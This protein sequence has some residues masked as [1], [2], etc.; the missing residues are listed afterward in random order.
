MILLGN[1]IAL[2]A[3]IF[4]VIAGLLKDRKRIIY[5]QSIQIFLFILS[6]AVLGGITGVITNLISLIRN[7]LCYKD[8]FN[9]KVKIILIAISIIFSLLFNNLGIIGL[10]PLISVV[11]YTY[12][13]DTKDVR[14]FKYIN[15]LATSLW[16]VYDI[17]ILSYTSAIFD[18]MCILANIITIFKM[19]K[20][21]N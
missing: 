2:M 1:I 13:M 21:N 10:L 12:L 5:V 14:K 17:Y 20:S 7:I 6:N 18:F 3:S 19:K 16:F 9:I 4:M 8:K 15:I 11:M